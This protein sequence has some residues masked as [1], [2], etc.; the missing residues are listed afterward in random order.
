MNN[1]APT[2][3]AEEF[4]KVSP[5]AYEGAPTLAKLCRGSGATLK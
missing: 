3:R 1:W 2:N 4:A 5:N